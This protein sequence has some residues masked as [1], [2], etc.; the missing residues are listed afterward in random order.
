MTQTQPRP[1]TETIRAVADHALPIAA[2]EQ[3][4]NRPLASIGLSRLYRT[5][6]GWESAELAQLPEVGT[7]ESAAELAQLLKAKDP[8]QI[9]IT[10]SAGLKQ[11]E[12]EAAMENAAYPKAVFLEV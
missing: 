8:A 9:L 3:A 6:Q 10:A 7:A 5:E 1:S 4:Y 11:S 12:V 2:R